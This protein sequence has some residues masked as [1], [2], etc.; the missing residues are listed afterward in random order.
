M[1]DRLDI[2]PAD[3]VLLVSIPQIELVFELAR[4]LE[5][6]SL[7]GL[8]TFEEIQAARRATRDLVN[9][10]FQPGSPEEI[11]WQ[12]GFFSKVIDLAGAWRD[13]AAAAREVARVL[14]PGG[15]AF[16]PE[17][18]S[19]VLLDAGLVVL[20]AEPALTALRKLG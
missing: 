1:I 12:D 11:P 20:A 2:R 16:V 7:V 5:R 14:A 19:Q 3:R 4:R 6:G 9:V 17:S 10:M 8:G 13:P 18:R 15:V